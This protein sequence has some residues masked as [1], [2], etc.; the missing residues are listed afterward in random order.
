MK[1]TWIAAGAALLLTALGLGGLYLWQHRMRPVQV[2]EAPAAPASAAAPAP[3]ASE[4]AIRHPLEAA[5]AA[6]AVTPGDAAP[7]W[8]QALIDTLGQSPVLRFVQTED[9]SRR[10]VVTV[11][12]LARGHAAP[13]L[14]PLNTTPGRFSV[15]GGDG[16]L[17]NIAAENARRYTPLVQ[18][19]ASVDARRAAELYARMYPQLQ[20]AYEENGYP[21]RYFNDRVVEV[22]DHLLATPEPAPGAPLVQLTEVKGS[23]PSTQPWL[24]YEF[25]DPQLQSL[26]SGQRILLRVGPQHREVLKAKLAELRRQIVAANR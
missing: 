5:P 9:F 14:W 7:S 25:A 24:R 23:V 21:G 8:R 12:N 6:S 15:S 10:F 3:V 2:A 13:A 20:K 22:I 11:D 4:P 19:V 18:W 26:S 16:E 17:R 1:R